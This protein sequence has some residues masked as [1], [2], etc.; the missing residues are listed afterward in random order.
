MSGAPGSR[1]TLSGI[2]Y[3]L[4]ETK[5]LA[6]LAEAGVSEEALL[7][8]RA[9]GLERFPRYAGSLEELCLAAIRRA[10]EKAQADPLAIDAAFFATETMAAGPAG[11]ESLKGARAQIY[12]ALHRAGTKHAFPA[13]ITYSGCA[14]FAASVAAAAGFIAT[15]ACRTAL[16][17]AVDVQSSDRIRLVPPAVAVMGDGAAACVVRAE[18]GNGMALGAVQLHANLDMHD[19]VPG[20]DMG[21]HMLEL[22]RSAKAMG[23]RMRAA[24]GRGPEAYRALVMNNYSLSTVR[25]LAHQLGYRFDQVF[26]ANIARTSHVSAADPLINLADLI[27]TEALRPGDRVMAFSS[28]PLSWGM[29]ELI[30]AGEDRNTP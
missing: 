4:G 30:Q 15:G 2:S 21:R 3:V 1:A 11:A 29:L 25:M 12:R 16:V 13:G 10:L 6:A 5:D 23:E 7:V 24:S 8:L 27:D 26:T 17:V 9:S 20:G 28:G 19:I 18:P 22:G 14:N